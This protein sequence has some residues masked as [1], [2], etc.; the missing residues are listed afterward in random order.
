MPS[1]AHEYYETL[2][3]PRTASASEIR[4]AHRKLARQFHPD[5]NPGDQLAEE[6]FKNV[7]EAYDVLIDPDARREYDRS[8]FHPDTGL[9]GTPAG[10]TGGAGPQP[11]ASPGSFEH[12]EWTR[13]GAGGYAGM[14]DFHV[15]RHDNR[16]SGASKGLLAFLVAFGAV[17]CSSVFPVPYILKWPIGSGLGE[18]WSLVPMAIL[19]ALGFVYGGTRGNIMT[20]SALIN[21]AA[22]GCLILYYWTEHI[23]QWPVITGMLP[24]VLPAQLPII[25]GM[26]FRRGTTI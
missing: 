11:A 2:G 25:L 13:G 16:I 22:W 6:R 4:R 5:L 3:V 7:Q 24:W 17:M 18:F 20:R 26:L 23:L 8:A 21:A 10:T 15:P 19:F 9:A 1:G 14:R 12:R